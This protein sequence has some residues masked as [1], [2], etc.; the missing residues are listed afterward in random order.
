M[1]WNTFANILSCR[2]ACR[3]L[4]VFLCRCCPFLRFQYRRPPACSTAPPPPG[5]PL[6]L[7]LCAGTAML[8][9]CFREAGVPVMPIDHQHNRHHP[10]AKVCNL[11]LTEDS[12]WSFLSDLVRDHTILFVHAA[13]PCGTCSMARSI[14]RKGVGGGSA[15]VAAVSHGASFASRF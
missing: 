5:E 9:R 1:M 10:L 12:T 7:E 2:P 15:A 8:S 11:S 4:L 13:P 3:G 6:F 14:K